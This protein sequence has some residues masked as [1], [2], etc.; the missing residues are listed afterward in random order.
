MLKEVKGFGLGGG[1]WIGIIQQVLNTNQDLLDGNGGTPAFFLV[2]NGKANG[3]RWI[4]VGV[5]EGWSEL[6]YMRG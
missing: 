2:E 3:A 4:H 1:V 6:A 5:K